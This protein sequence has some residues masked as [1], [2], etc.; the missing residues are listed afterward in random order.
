MRSFF[1]LLNILHIHL[2]FPN[3][4]P[5]IKFSNGEAHFHC[6]PSMCVSCNTDDNGPC[7]DYCSSSNL[8]QKEPIYQPISGDKDCR[9]CTKEGNIQ[10]L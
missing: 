10:A 9:G 4:E 1:Y 6:D 3:S 7:K 2:S 5:Q 8:C